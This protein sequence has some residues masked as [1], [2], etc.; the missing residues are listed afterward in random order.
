MHLRAHAHACINKHYTVHDRHVKLGYCSV[1]CN[2][3]CILTHMLMMLCKKT[4]KNPIKFPN[5]QTLL[6]YTL[7]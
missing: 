4:L 2:Y 5:S 1:I 6:D 3:I 7:L